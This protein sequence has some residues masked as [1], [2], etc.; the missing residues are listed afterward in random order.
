MLQITIPG[1]DFFFFAFRPPWLEVISQKDFNQYDYY[2]SL[3]PYNYN[4]YTKDRRLPTKRFLM[5]ACHPLHALI[6]L[7]LSAEQVRT[8]YLLILFRVAQ[9]KEF[10]LVF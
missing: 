2:F 3:G 10:Y 9:H 8:K 5:G 1:G 6:F 7:I 4:Y